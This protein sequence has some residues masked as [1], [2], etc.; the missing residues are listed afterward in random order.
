MYRNRTGTVY[1]ATGSNPVSANSEHGCIRADSQH[2][3]S[4]CENLPEGLSTLPNTSS[5]RWNPEKRRQ[6]FLETGGRSAPVGST[7]LVTVAVVIVIKPSPKSGG[8][9]RRECRIFPK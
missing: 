6:K 9:S 5:S 4:V 1:P 3:I 2:A 8:V 7:P